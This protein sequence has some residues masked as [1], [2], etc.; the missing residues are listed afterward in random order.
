MSDN[1]RSVEMAVFE[2]NLMEE[3]IELGFGTPLWEQSPGASLEND[4]NIPI[5]ELPAG[6]PAG[7]P[8]EVTFG[9]DL[10]GLL[11]ITAVEK[12]S[13]QKCNFAI[14]TK[15]L[16]EDKVM[17]L[18]RE[19]SAIKVTEDAEPSLQAS[20]AAP[21]NNSGGDDENAWDF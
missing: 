1:Q 17:E 7:T 12:S 16:S 15:G 4:S 21:T 8:L 3:V 11:Q 9:L 5:L 19:T 18:R 13:G 14:K 20:E 10:N 2:S 6:L